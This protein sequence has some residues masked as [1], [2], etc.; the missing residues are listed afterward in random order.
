MKK[1]AKKH[2]FGF[3]LKLRAISYLVKI[4][5]RNGR[6]ELNKFSDD[7]LGKFPEK[8]TKNIIL[9]ACDTNY[10]WKHGVS[11]LNSAFKSRFSGTIHVHVTEPQKDVLESLSQ[12][13]CKEQVNLNVT[14]S[15]D[16]GNYSKELPSKNVYYT[17]VR[18]IVAGLLAQAG[19]RSILIVDIDAV[20]RGSPWNRLQALENGKIGFIF[21][22]KEKKHWRRILAS[23][24][25]YSASSTSA[26]FADRYARALCLALSNAPR[27]HIDQV[28]PYYLI[29]GARGE[30]SLDF[31]QI[32]AEL[33][34]YN[35][36]EDAEFWTVKGTVNKSGDK[37]R[38]AQLAAIEG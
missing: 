33:M 16:H 2:K 23:A 25:Y 24:V 4:S 19:C 21:R 32:P 20:M 11:F 30:R 7:L 12:W 15:Y 34:G 3:L 38:A 22:P 14:Y 31:A 36:E 18:F 13:S 37:F 8:D 1:K 6:K 26:V 29:R 10:Y 17:C 28:L 9:V 35:F 5:D 27:Y